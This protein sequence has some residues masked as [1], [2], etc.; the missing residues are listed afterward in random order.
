MKGTPPTRIARWIVLSEA[1]LVLGACS[2]QP[3]KPEDQI[4]EFLA[5]AEKAVHERDL[6][7]VKALIA[8]D[9]RDAEQRDKPA[10]AGMV[11]YQFMQQGSLHLS[12][13]L[14]SVEFPAA[15][16]AKAGV[17]A[18]LGRAHVDL[19]S[20]PDLNGDIYFFSLDLRRG[21]NGWQATRAEW[22]QA[23]VDDLS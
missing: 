15:D 3:A 8:A 5:R 20:L 18:A 4:R 16:T 13:R 1:L 10:L 19:T 9:Y 2:R 21:D 14:Q 7:G 6:A 17:I 23:T 12:T 11:A 22:R